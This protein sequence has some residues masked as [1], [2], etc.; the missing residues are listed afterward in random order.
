MRK[1]KT[2]SIEKSNLITQAVCAIFIIMACFISKS[3]MIIASLISMVYIFSDA[4]WEQKFAFFFFMLSFSPI[5]KLDIEQTSLFMFLRVSVIAC[6]LFKEREK[7]TF[8]FVTILI[9]FFLYSL[10]ISEIF[11][12]DYLTTLINIVLWLMIGYVLINTSN[13]AKMTPVTRSLSNGVIITGII[14]LFVEQIPQISENLI[15]DKIYAEDGYLITRYAGF[16]SDPNY[17]TVLVVASLFA[18]YFEFNN[19]R[20]N[21]AEFI[22]RSAAVSFLGLMTMSKSCAIVLF[23]FWIYVFLSKNDI[24]TEA[25]VVLFFAFF[26]VSAWFLIKNPY[27]LSDILYRFTG[28]SDEVTSDVLTTGRT[29]LWKT[30]MSY[31][32]ENGRWLH[33][34]GIGAKLVG[35]GAPHNSVIYLFYSFGLFGIILYISVFIILYISAKRTT[36]IAKIATRRTSPAKI[37]LFV[38]FFLFIFLDCLNF[39]PLY[40]ILPMLFVYH[41][42]ENKDSDS[43]VEQAAN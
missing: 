8:S 10:F 5:F 25:K 3:L 13:E 34:V 28:G 1:I 2:I 26:I 43:I 16:W 17:F 7:I 23:I 4:K 41:L 30:Y 33:G 6:Y 20:I 38:I 21:V 12:T 39:E 14:G 15:V 42:G 27:W 22:I 9:A 31:L 24:K 19:K 18:L 29:S 40:Y 36:S 35:D 11:K 37:A 32:L